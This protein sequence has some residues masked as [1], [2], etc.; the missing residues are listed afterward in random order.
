VVVVV[1]V[2]VVLEQAEA[3]CRGARTSACRCCAY[4]RT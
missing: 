3:I 1:V 2:A 4:R